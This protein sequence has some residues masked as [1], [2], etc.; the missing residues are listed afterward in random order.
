MALAGRQQSWEEIDRLLSPI[1]FFNF[2]SLFLVFRR[3]LAVTICLLHQDGSTRIRHQGP[4][5]VKV[6]LGCVLILFRLGEEIVSRRDSFKQRAWWPGA[7]FSD[8]RQEQQH[9]QDRIR[10]SAGPIS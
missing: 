8:L 1:V 10:S 5:P 4:R 3:S 2:S 9:V 6:P 7:R